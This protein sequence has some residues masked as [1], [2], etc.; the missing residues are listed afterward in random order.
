MAGAGQGRDDPP[1]DPASR[2]RWRKQ[3]LDWFH[4][5]LVA[6]SKAREGRS[7]QAG[8]TTVETL[9]ELGVEYELAGLRDAPS[10]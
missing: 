3:A 2:A 9:Q 5:D 6:R 8:Q 7:R 1:L 4:A 10:G